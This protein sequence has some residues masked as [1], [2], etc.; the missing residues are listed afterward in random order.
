M[1]PEFRRNVW[2]E[3]APLRL[4]VLVAVLLLTFFAAALTEGL[5]GPGSVARWAYYFLVVV[6]GTRNAARSVVGEMRDRTWDGQRL[7]SLKAS[8]MVWGKLFGSTVFPWI[9]GAICLAVIIADVVNHSGA[10]AAAL[11]FFYYIALGVIAQAASLLASLVAAGRRQSRTQF[12]VFLYQVVGI[13]AGVAVWAIAD[14]S[15]A[16]IGGIPHTDT[17]SWWGMVLPTQPFLLLSL[18]AFAGW[19]L[20]GNYRLMRLE[21]KLRN[22]PAA[23]LG[24]LSF[25]VLY[26]AGF[27]AW[28]AND[29]IHGDMI[30]RR[31]YLAGV[32]CAGLT[33]L[34]VFLEP[35]DRVFFRWLGSA[36]AQ[37][38]LGT[39]FGR[40]Q[41]WMMSGLAALLFG[42]ALVARLASLGWVA[43]EAALGA[44]LGFMTRDMGLVVLMNMA[45]RRRGGD[46]AGLAVL[47][48]L[49]GLMPPI[50]GALHYEMGQ[51]LFLPRVTVPIWLSPSAAWLEAA[52]V[53]IVACA[54]IALPED[55]TKN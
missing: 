34:T 51:A 16:S 49:Y 3:L 42:G 38:H 47:G 29:L 21:L 36:F 50:I 46:L 35:K 52:A 41:C 28:G 13:V 26:V 54:Q 53:W 33:Y 10:A 5:A 37:F 55:R 6:W 4:V 23:W 45:A 9:G 1:N 8:T 14:P 17:V 25:M 30:A 48:L 27:D 22:G 32:V 7:S 24:F 43:D 44:M 39:G 20:L 11:Q 31:L 40:F 18:A 19:M 12:E 15:G 2:L